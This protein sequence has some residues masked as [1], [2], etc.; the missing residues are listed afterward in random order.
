MKFLF[1]TQ[2]Q[3]I[4]QD[5]KMW[6]MWVR[7]WDLTHDIIHGH[8]ANA[9]HKLQTDAHALPFAA[10]DASLERGADATVTGL[11]QAETVNDT[12]CLWNVI[13]DKND[14]FHDVCDKN[15]VFYEVCDK[16]YFSY[17]V[18]PI[19]K[20]MHSKSLKNRETWQKLSNYR[21]IFIRSC[22]NVPLFRTF[23]SNAAHAPWLELSPGPK[24]ITIWWARS[25]LLQY[26]VQTC[27]SAGIP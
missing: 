24:Y 1:L 9:R 22:K 14:V 19:E 11:G 21:R 23:E 26:L 5:L 2:S 15:D 17:P 16:Q 13:C 25:M 8:P 10:R 6:G 3:M 7:T 12:I 27:S 18:A 4:V 20:S